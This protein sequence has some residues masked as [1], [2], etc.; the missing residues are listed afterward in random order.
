MIKFSTAI[1]LWATAVAVS[2]GPAV[3]AQQ[4]QTTTPA[5]DTVKARTNEVLLDVVVRDKKGRAVNDLK[6][7][8]F[9]ILDN[10]EAQKVA[11]FRLVQ[12]AEAIGAGGA[13]AELD[14][15]RQVRLVT[16]IFHCYN[17]D[18]RRLAHDAALDLLKG[19][20]PQ[21]VY[22]AVMTI[23]HKLEV[24]QPFTND[25][26]LLRKAMD[27]A[28]G[29][30]NTDFSKDT[31]LVRSHLEQM[32]GPNTTGAQSTQGQID[33]RASTLAAQGRN[34][35][36]ADLATVAMAQMLLQM[37]QT[38][39]ANAMTEGGRAEIYALLDSVKEQYRLPGRK[40]I[41]YFSEGGFTIPQGMEEPFKT[42]ISIANHSNVS[43]YAVDAR[44]LTTLSAN[45][46]GIDQLKRAAQSSQDQQTGGSSQ[47]VRPDEAQLFDT[48][49]QTTRANT[50][51][52]LAN[53]A[54]ST[55]GV[56]IANTNDFRTPLRKLAED[57]QTYY[58][59]TYNPDIKN[60]D[61][62]FRKISINMS[63]SEL[64]VQSRSGYI[65]LPPALAANGNVL[66]AFEVPLLM[67]LD[68]P[69]LPRAFGFESEATHFRGP[70]NQPVCD[71]VVDVPLSDVTFQKGNA[72]QFEGRLS[73]V[74]LLKDSRGEVVKKFQNEIP[75]N[76]PADK[77]D[78]LKA[79]HFIYTEHF[80]LP[81]GRY[82]LETAVLDGEGKRISARRSSLM[83]P[84][85]ST[86]LGISSVCIVRSM[87]DND[88]SA[89]DFDPFAIESKVVS[90]TLAPVISKADAKT[91]PF[92]L[93]IYADKS[94]AAP[95]QLVMEFSRN[96]VVLGSGSPALGPPD[97]NGRIQY[98][99]M[100]P[101]AQ[102]EP[103][104]FKIRFVVT[105]GSETAEETASFTL[106]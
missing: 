68:S 65:A 41:L 60:Y 97:K 105:Q 86:A 57:I 99:A 55:G 18:A 13:R 23:D 100:A 61:G 7:E 42:V 101:V 51:S 43:F 1:S 76:V 90:P 53:L 49:I 37:I 72:G 92:Y 59:I 56:L 88:G 27:R 38:E 66:H 39:Q 30:Q 26:A 104:E 25:P 89:A 91:L 12:G 84:P 81:P 64:R 48:A 40:A 85:L 36:P 6:A 63:S 96:G 28:T 31:E 21:N 19:E 62:S 17:N 3:L 15:L 103:G 83:M 95:P 78:A 4:P 44:G 73:Y 71:L 5:E 50:Q 11:S 29:S 24:L 8:D 34:A 80:D 75:L 79:S 45:Q 58:E 74:A 46:A 52:T 98:I 22:M 87:K 94:V 2:S 82:T 33:N 20:L 14:P 93:V 16:M 10:G 67:A 106:Q 77:L 69:E 32:L 54:E 35:N 47:P 70:Q 9:H 102:L